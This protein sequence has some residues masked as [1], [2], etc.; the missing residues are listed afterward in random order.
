MRYTLPI[1]LITLFISCNYTD[2][3]DTKPYDHL[4]PNSWIEELEEGVVS[5]DV[6]IRGVV[7]TSDSCGN[8]YQSM[9]VQDPTAALEV[10]L[11]FYD[12]YTLYRRNEMVCLRLEGINLKLEN[13]VLVANYGSMPIA[14]QRIFRAGHSNDYIEPIKLHIDELDQSY[15]GLYIELSGGSFTQGGTA[16]WSGERTYSL[17]GSASIRVYTSPFATYASDTL[18][19]GNV[20]LRGILT[21]YNDHLQF[22]MSTSEDILF[23]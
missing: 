23:D 15:T 21:I 22:R 8:F 1:L 5:E 10:R 14:G 6:V 16:V 18:P 19:K 11:G 20:S 17:K 3:L 9:M 4:E 12:I 2:N 7:T 13:G